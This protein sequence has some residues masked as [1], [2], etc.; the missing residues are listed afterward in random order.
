M[1][2]GKL[3]AG[4]CS[5]VVDEVYQLVKSATKVP[6]AADSQA[7][8]IIGGNWQSQ[9]GPVTLKPTGNASEPNGKVQLTG[10]WT[11]PSK[12]VGTIE[13]GSFDPASGTL[14]FA[15]YQPWNNIR[16]VATFK[17]SKDGKSLVGSFSQPP[18]YKGAWTL[19]R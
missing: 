4:R 12:G 7:S 13:Q 3:V 2:R 15:Y 19:N 10:S 9:W 16:G 5:I 8:A 18:N 17:L 1:I 6:A 14:E 11:Q